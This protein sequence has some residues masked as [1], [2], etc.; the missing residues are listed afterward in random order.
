[1]TQPSAGFT[2]IAEFQVKP[3][4]RDAFVELAHE[5]ARRSLA[6]EPGCHQFDVLIGEADPNLVV[7]HEC[8][9]DREAFETHMNMPHYPPFKSGSEPLLATAP[10]VRFFVTG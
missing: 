7:L 4:Q 5:D 8:Y 3:G 10:H 1:M 2:V 9:T 6:D